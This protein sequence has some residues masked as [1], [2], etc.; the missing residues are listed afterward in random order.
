MGG[1]LPARWIK[2][3][4]NSLSLIAAS[5][6]ANG[7]GLMDEGTVEMLER[8]YLQYRQSYNSSQMDSTLKR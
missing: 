4:F 2:E 3:V 7:P 6:A 8:H 5:C 1:L